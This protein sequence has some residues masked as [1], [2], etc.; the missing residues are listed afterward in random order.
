MAKYGKNQDKNGDG[1]VLEWYAQ[2]A[3]FDKAIVGKVAGDFAALAGD[4]G[5]ATGD[6]ATAGC[7]MAIGDMIKAA[8][9]ATK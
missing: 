1:I 3:E 9:A 7:T 2:A 6:L 8:T 5:Y 4:D